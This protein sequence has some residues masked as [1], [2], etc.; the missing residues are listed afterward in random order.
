MPNKNAH[1][2][3]RTASAEVEIPYETLVVFMSA[4]PRV[5]GGAGVVEEIKSSLPDTVTLNPSQKAV[6]VDVLD[7]WL[8]DELGDKFRQLREEFRKDLSRT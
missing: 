8:T 1:V 2:I 7:D 6:A 3:F 5:R 4:L